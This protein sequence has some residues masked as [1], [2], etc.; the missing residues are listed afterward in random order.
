M[1]YVVHVYVVY[2]APYAQHILFRIIMHSLCSHDSPGWIGIITGIGKNVCTHNHLLRIVNLRR[3][4]K[5]NQVHHMDGDGYRW[6][7]YGNL[8]KYQL[9]RNTQLKNFL[10]SHVSDKVTKYLFDD[11]KISRTI[12]YIFI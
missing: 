6:E 9:L 1:R 10:I 8:L 12:I 2:K 4:D 7:R 3:P 5:F 11:M